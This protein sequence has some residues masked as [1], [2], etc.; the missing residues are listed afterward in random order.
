[1]NPFALRGVYFDIVVRKY[2]KFLPLKEVFI[3]PLLN[4]SQTDIAL[5]TNLDVNE[6][7]S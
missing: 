6:I 3:T 5:M 4:N 7:F 1:M 2:K